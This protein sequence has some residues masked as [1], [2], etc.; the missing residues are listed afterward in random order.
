[1]ILHS[2]RDIENISHDIL[3]TS[4]SLGVFPTPVDKIVLHS[5]LVMAGGIDLKSLEKKYKSSFFTEALKSGLAKVR[6]FLDRREKVIYV[7]LEQKASRQNFVKLHETGHNVLPWQNK[8]L[9]F[10]DDDGTLDPET[11]E[12]FE[13]EANYFASVTLFQGE[14]F[15]EEVKKFEIG[16]PTVVQ[17]SNHFGA[18]VHATF[19]WYVERSKFKCALLVLKNLSSKGQVPN[20]ELRNAFH[21]DSFLSAFGSIEWPQNFGFK[22][23]FIQDHLFLRKK[24]KVNGTIQLKTLDGEVE[25]AYHYFDNTY[26]A[27]V[28]IFP[29][30]ESQPTKN[31]ILIKENAGV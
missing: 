26:N 8:W 7:D 25:F 29:K 18:S 14:R 1:M 9:E 23:A 11:Q 20:G 6:G 15:E 17:L 22:W 13:A 3:K 16:L 27:F 19:R 21:S 10:L 4:K 2:Q 28:L 31:K 12:E 24:W 30:G 5:E